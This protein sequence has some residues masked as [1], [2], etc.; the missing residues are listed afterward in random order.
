MSLIHNGLRCPQC[1][2]TDPSVFFPRGNPPACPDCGSPRVTWWGH[3]HAHYSPNEGAGL[4]LGDVH[5]RYREMASTRSGL[6]ALE[7]E[8]SAANGG[9][10][11]EFE[12]PSH[13]RI[14]EREERMQ[15]EINF[16][17][18]NGRDMKEFNE[19]QEA[20]KRGAK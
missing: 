15:R 12:T 17:K 4:D 8:L 16:R 2:R 1:G 18:L 19:R 3:G 14:V 7:K 20:I 9:K 6:R 10:R 5:P 13:R 11:I